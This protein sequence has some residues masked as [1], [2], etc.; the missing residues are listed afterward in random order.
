MTQRLGIAQ[1]LVNEPDLLV[2]DE[3]N[4]GLDLTGRQL[5]PASSA[6]SGSKGGTVML[7]SHV[8][9]EVEQLCD[10]VAVIVG[11]RLAYTGRRPS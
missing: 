7:V 8:L 3:P 10:R 11:G 2:L 9:P 4:E 6:S 5:M 1:A